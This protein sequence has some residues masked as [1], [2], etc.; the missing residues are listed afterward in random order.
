MADGKIKIQIVGEAGNDVTGSCIWIKTSHSEIL[1]ECGLYQCG[2]DTLKEYQINNAPFKF[3]AK[4]ISYVFGCHCHSDHINRIPLLYKR[5]MQGTFIMPC[6]SSQIARILMEDCAKISEN[7]AEELSKRYKRNYPPLFTQQDVDDCLKH[8]CEYPMGVW[9]DLDEYIRFR[10]IPSGHILEAAQLELSITEGNITKLIGYT[11]DLGNLH[12]S[13]NFVNKF[14]PISRANIFIGETT[15][16]G[17]DRIATQS[18]R[19]KDLEKLKSAIRDTCEERGGRVLIPCFANARSQELLTVLFD[20]FGYDSS[21]RTSVI[22]DT[23]MGIRVC[24]AYRDLLCE[25]EKDKF[26][27]V[28]AW[29][30]LKFV[31]DPEISKSYQCS[32]EPAV[33]IS[34]SG[35]LTNGRSRQ[36]VKNMLNSDRNL[37]IFCGYSVDNSLASLIKSGERKFIKLGGKRIANRCRV[38]DLHSFTSHMQKDSLLSYYGS[39]DCE[40]VILV[41][42]KMENKLKFATELEETISKNNKTSKVV[43]ATKGYSLLL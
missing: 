32:S 33:I 3:K 40:K 39:V 18:V 10:F 22:F 23:P 25:A 17:E 21:F 42:G 28:L 29:G 43:C 31:S 15:Y 11:S 35:M 38:A 20:L 2:S 5:G 14:E 1:I 26:E 37:I 7:D 16:S 6:G 13:R 19:N 24:E 36:Y 4:N 34:S 12:I 8:I 41:H 27:S 30:N 9:I